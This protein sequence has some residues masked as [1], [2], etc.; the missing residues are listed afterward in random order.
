LNKSIDRKSET[1]TKKWAVKELNLVNR[2]TKSIIPLMERSPKELLEKIKQAKAIRE[3][4][5]N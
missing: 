3:H 2:I 5:V 1:Q 4:N